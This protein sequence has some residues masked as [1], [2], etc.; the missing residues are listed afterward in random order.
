[1]MKGTPVLASSRIN[2]YSS[3]QKCTHLILVILN[4]I[5]LEKSYPLFLACVAVIDR[6]ASNHP[7]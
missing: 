1:M 3:S 2:V 7:I 4:C 6:T 5:E